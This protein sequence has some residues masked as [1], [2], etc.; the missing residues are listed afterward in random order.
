MSV[1][2]TGP[3]TVAV[4]VQLSI[5]LEGCPFRGT[6]RCLVCEMAR[7]CPVLCEFICLRK[8]PHMGVIECEHR[9]DCPCGWSDPLIRQQ[10][11][12]SWLAAQ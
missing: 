11:Y 9:L 2:D 8:K 12:E 6:P 10:V 3:V 5:S 4:S 1:L 7:A